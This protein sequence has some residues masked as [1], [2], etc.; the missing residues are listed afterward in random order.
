V[1]RLS[2]RDIDIIS[3]TGSLVSSNQLG[4]NREAVISNRSYVSENSLKD[5]KNED[6]EIIDNSIILY[7]GTKSARE[8][9][10]SKR[11][12]MGSFLSSNLDIAKRFANAAQQHGRPTVLKISVPAAAAVFPQGNTYWSLNEPINLN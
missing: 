4:G 10:S 1:I 9:D 7:H 6:A 3:Y 2:I 12:K 11:L 5:A 8:I